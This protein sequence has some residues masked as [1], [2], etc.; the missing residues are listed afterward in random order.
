[1]STKTVKIKEFGFFKEA[2]LIELVSNFSFVRYYVN[3]KGEN[4]AILQ[5]G[6]WQSD[7]LKY[8]KIGKNV[9]VLSINQM[10]SI[11]Q[12]FKVY[13]ITEG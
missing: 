8:V 6:K 9:M 4:I 7:V 3:D 5:H 11:E 10:P 1:M 13:E 12:R 2:S